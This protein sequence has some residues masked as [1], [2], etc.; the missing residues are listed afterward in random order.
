MEVVRCSVCFS[1]SPAGKRSREVSEAQLLCNSIGPRWP[2]LFASDLRKAIIRGRDG[3]QEPREM[4][5]GSPGSKCGGTK[6]G[7]GLINVY[8]SCCH[9]K[10]SPNT[11]LACSALKLQPSLQF[12]ATVI[13]ASSLF[14]TQPKIDIKIIQKEQKNLHNV[15]L[16]HI[17]CAHKG[18]FR[19][20]RRQK[21]IEHIE[22]NFMNKMS[23]LYLP[24]MSRAH[25]LNVCHISEDLLNSIYYNVMF[26]P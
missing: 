4:N 16:F 13:R 23:P 25:Y 6:G 10:K 3:D 20:S 26:G 15:P 22:T 12:Q 11:L 5:S 1:T 2:R 14:V 7:Q 21:K 8:R 19:V 17:R 9:K 24:L 18:R